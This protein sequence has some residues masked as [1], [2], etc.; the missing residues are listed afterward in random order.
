MVRKGEK[1]SP[2]AAAHLAAA[3]T[4]A[5]ESLLAK[6]EASR[7]TKAVARKLVEERIAKVKI[8]AAEEGGASLRE[9]KPQPPDVVQRTTSYGE[10]EPVLEEPEAEP[11]P[12]PAPARRPRARAHSVD[13]GDAEDDKKNTQRVDSVA[14]A[15]AR[16]VARHVVKAQ[17]TKPRSRRR[18]AT[19]PPSSD[20]ETESYASTTTDDTSESE[21]EEDEPPP[22]R[23]RRAPAPAPKKPARK[24]AP[25]KPSLPRQSAQEQLQ[26]RVADEALRMAMS[27]LYA[28]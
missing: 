2:E 28:C 14:R 18:E 13:A 15:F 24:P 16:K 26:A 21:S 7:A 25:K 19:P 1:L 3:R 12:E 10:A 23:R 27:Q 20:S 8:M 4:K 6:G 22:R 17:A 5:R 9:A 11:E